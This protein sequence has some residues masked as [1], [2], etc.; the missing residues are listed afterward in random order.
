MIVTPTIARICVLGDDEYL[1]FGPG[2]WYVRG[3]ADDGFRRVHRRSEQERLDEA[4]GRAAIR[5]GAL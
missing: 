2:K 3:R 1:R 4:F 5:S